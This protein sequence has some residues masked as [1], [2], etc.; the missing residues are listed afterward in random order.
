M[1]PQ[2]NTNPPVDIPDL[3]GY[4]L[5]QIRAS[6]AAFLPQLE[7]NK[8]TP[9]IEAVSDV[10]GATEMAKTYKQRVKIGID[11]DKTPIYKWATGHSIDEL[12]DS[13]V[14]LYVEH[15]LIERF[16][17][18]DR[19]MKPAKD[20]IPT[21]REYAR[22]WFETF[23]KPK[24]KPTTLQGY[25]SNMRKHL[26]PA[27]GDLR[28]DTITP[29]TVQ[30]F[31]N[32][33]AALAKNTVHTMFV[34][35][36]EIMDSAF[37][38]CLIPS[39]P[40]KSKRISIPSTK[41]TE[42]KALSPTQLKAIIKEIAEKLTDETERRL[43]S[44]MLFTGMRRGEILGL[45]WDDIDFEQKLITVNRAVSY[46]TNQPIVSTPKTN[47]GY[48]IVPLDPQLEEFLKPHREAG[49]VIGGER[50]PTQMVLRRILRHVN[51]QIDLFGATPHVFRHSYIS[52]LAEASVDFRTIQRISGHSQMQTTIGYMHSRTD[53]VKQAGSQV[54]RMFKD[55]PGEPG[56]APASA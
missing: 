34:L 24:L 15:C 1:N 56:K 5:E 54:G 32:E 2:K 36:S 35:F 4:T 9:Q 22:N 45:R 14:R 46:T 12:N 3:S 10:K 18:V 48:R 23:K 26:F 33:R 13:V 43:I 25:Q 8:G 31:L 37:E 42:R 28:L 39:N 16:L 17:H 49:Y 55:A 50:P 6:L 40:A 38:D 27:F 29:E 21:F 11:E 20:E 51:Q 30:T 19:T 44:L 52:A 47:N 53:L 41:K 7:N